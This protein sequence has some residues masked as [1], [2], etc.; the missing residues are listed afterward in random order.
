[1]AADTTNATRARCDSFGDEVMMTKCP[2][3]Y[4]TFLD[5]GGLALDEA[6]DGELVARPHPLPPSATRKGPLAGEASS[7]TN[8]L[9]PAT[10]F[11]AA[12]S[13]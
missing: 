2:G 6:A 12:A 8:S 1:M 9:G 3:Y 13:A 10:S 5:G 11:G 7:S 4:T